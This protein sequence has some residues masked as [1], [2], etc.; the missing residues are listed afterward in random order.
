LDCY[1]YIAT[2]Q[3]ENKREEKKRYNLFQ[4]SLLRIDNLNDLEKSRNGTAIYGITTMA[5]LSFEEFAEE[6]LG[7]P[8][9]EM[10][11]DERRSLK[12]S[13]NVVYDGFDTGAQDWTGILTTPVKS[14]GQCSSCW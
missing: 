8:P 12:E 3:Y 9:T 14:Q 4:E 11:E 1:L 5:D 13:P 2:R 7:G 6:Y 10:D